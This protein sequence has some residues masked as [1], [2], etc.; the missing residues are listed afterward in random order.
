MKDAPHRKAWRLNLRKESDS[1]R[2]A[3]SSLDK[4]TVVVLL[5]CAVAVIV[6]MKLGDRSYFRTEIA[7]RLD[8]QSVGLAS[9]SW[10]F[11]VQGILGFLIPVIILRYGFKQTSA[12]MGLGLGD[13]RFAGI[14]ALVYVPVVVIGTWILSDN[15]EFQSNYPH[16]GPAASDWS[17][18]LIYEAVFVFYWIGWEYLWRGFVLFGTAQVFGLYAII[19]QTVPF[20]ILHYEK[21]FPEALLSIVGGLAL[22]ALVWRTRSFWIAVPIHSLQMLLIDLFCSLRIRSGV[23]GV[24]PRALI[25]L[26]DKL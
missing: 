13:W 5:F 19:I 10:W 12:E 23:S 25:D 8:L 11:A 26:F 4:K 22:G 2:R 17:V 6:Q 15:V 1:V 3:L 14:V 18:F 9:W 20:A 24:S 7:P 21:P 16:Y